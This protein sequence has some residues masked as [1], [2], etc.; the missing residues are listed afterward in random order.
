MSEDERPKCWKKDMTALAG[1]P[2]CISKDERGQKVEGSAKVGQ[3]AT[4]VL[5]SILSD[6]PWLHVPWEALLW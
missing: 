1:A 6:E 4:Q 5:L 3:T 2:P